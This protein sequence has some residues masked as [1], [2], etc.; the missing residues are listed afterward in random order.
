MQLKWLNIV[1][2]GT[3]LHSLWVNTEAKH[4]PGLSGIKMCSV[5]I[6]NWLSYADSFRDFLVC[7]ELVWGMT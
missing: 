5:Y 4:F 1:P 7:V 2:G 3:V 6:I